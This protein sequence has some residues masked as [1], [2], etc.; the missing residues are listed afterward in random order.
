MFEATFFR[1]NSNL[2]TG[3]KS[4]NKDQYDDFLPISIMNNKET[5]NGK[6][7][8]VRS[9]V[10]SSKFDIMNNAVFCKDGHAFCEKCFYRATLQSHGQCLFDNTHLG[11]RIKK[12]VNLPIRGMIASLKI[13]CPSTLSE[14]MQCEWRGTVDS[15]ADHQKECTMEIVPCS[16]Q[17][18]AVKIYP[19][20]MEDHS[21]KCP[22]ATIAC[23]K[24]GMQIQA[25][26]KT[27]KS[28]CIKETVSCTNNCGQDVTRYKGFMSYN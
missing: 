2:M 17:G 18:C 25:Q 24:C 15:M 16:N 11:L 21:K 9:A 5:R 13:K 20:E 1:D 10:S 27:H 26:I 8:E 28:K 12:T 23:T 19:S 6:F 22:L 3:T 7:Y 4:T 14:H